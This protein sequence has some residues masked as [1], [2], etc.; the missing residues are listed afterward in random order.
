MDYRIR[1]AYVC[2]IA[3]EPARSFNLTQSKRYFPFVDTSDAFLVDLAK[4]KRPL[5][6]E[7]NDS[8]LAITIGQNDPGS[9]SPKMI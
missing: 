3:N 7:N 4:N 1:P 6:N 8:F 5:G 9:H 2:G